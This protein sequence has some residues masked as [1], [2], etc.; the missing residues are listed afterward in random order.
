MKFWMIGTLT[1][2]FSFWLS[3]NSQALVIDTTGSWDGI[4][5]TCCFGE[6]STDTYGQTFF[7]STQDTLL[8]SF[9]FWIDDRTDV[10]APVD[11]AGYIMEW[12]DLTSYGDYRHTV[13]PL[14]YSSAKVTTTNNKGTGGM[15]EITFNTGALE[16]EQGKKYVAFISSS[17]FWDGKNSSGSVGSLGSCCNGS[18]DVYGGSEFVLVSNGNNFMPYITQAGWNTYPQDLAFVANFSSPVVASPVPEPE[19][20][21]MLLAGLGLWGFT[22]WRRK[23]NGAIWGA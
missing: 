2:F 13:G 14:L 15:E 5:G 10:N 4:A 22:S 21:S 19:T 6:G 12:H 23:Q 3:C 8:N 9:S 7:V 17:L 11:F 1:A 16:L 20:Y 18:G